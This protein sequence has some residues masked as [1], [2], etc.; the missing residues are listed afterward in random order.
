M[1]WDP[2]HHLRRCPSCRIHFE[3]RRWH[4]SFQK[5]PHLGKVHEHRFSGPKAIKKTYV[6]DVTIVAHYENRLKRRRIHTSSLI[7]HE[8]SAS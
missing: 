6:P 4:F 2:P 1:Y 7:G 3:H 5:A 8:T